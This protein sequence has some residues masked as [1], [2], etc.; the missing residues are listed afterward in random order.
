MLFSF[1]KDKTMEMLHT[2]FNDAPLL[3]LFVT[4]PIGY[5]VG[6]FRIN[7]FVLEG[8]AGTLLVGVLVG[9]IGGDIDSDLKT[10]IHQPAYPLQIF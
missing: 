4:L 9:Q 2:L 1:E 7:R 5:L 8:I 6:K 10:Y 3:A